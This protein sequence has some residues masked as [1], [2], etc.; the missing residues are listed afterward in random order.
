M[1]RAPTISPLTTKGE[2]IL[3]LFAQLIAQ[4]VQKEWLVQQLTIANA[5]LH[6]YSY[7]DSLTGL[8]NRRGVFYSLEALFSQAENDNQQVLIVF[9]DLDGFKKINDQFGHEAGDIFLQEVGQRLLKW[10]NPG[11][12]VGRLGGDEFVFARMVNIAQGENKRILSSFRDS[13]TPLLQGNYLIGTV[14][15]EYLGASMGIVMADPSIDEPDS[16]IRRADAAMYANKVMRKKDQTCVFDVIT[17]L[18]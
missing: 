6:E 8:L 9:I 1:L 17:L 12:V 13:I 15:I 7:T 10:G 16:V 14:S 4:Q 18:P 5:A 2:Q 3:S 11:D